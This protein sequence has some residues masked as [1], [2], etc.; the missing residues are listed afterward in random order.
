V[1]GLEKVDQKPYNSSIKHMEA[2]QSDELRFSN[3]GSALEE[4]W[5]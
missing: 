5:K 4:I 1:F 2:M 3:G